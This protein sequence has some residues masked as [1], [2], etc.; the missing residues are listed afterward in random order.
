MLNPT[1][2]FRMERT[3]RRV[4][5]FAIVGLT[6]LLFSAAIVATNAEA[7]LRRSVTVLDSIQMST[8]DNPNYAL[9]TWR[10]DDIDTDIGLDE[11]PGQLSGLVGGD[12][13]GKTEHD[14]PERF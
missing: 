7:D 9:G 10:H 6:W 8:F 11:Q 4:L 1:T 13:T 3:V 2:E 5:R 12:A 14:T